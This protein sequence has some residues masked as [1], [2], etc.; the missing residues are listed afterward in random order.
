[1][2]VCVGAGGVDAGAGVATGVVVVV[3]VEVVWTAS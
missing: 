3:V 1:M 2:P